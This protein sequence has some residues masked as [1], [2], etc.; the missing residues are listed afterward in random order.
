M[1]RVVALLI[2]EDLEI[3]LVQELLELPLGA[4]APVE[5]PL[6]LERLER[7][8]VVRIVA[9]QRLGEG[10]Q[11]VDVDEADL[12]A[13]AR[14]GRRVEFWAIP[15]RVKPLEVVLVHRGR[16]LVRIVEA[17]EDDSDEEVEEN[18][19]DDHVEYDH[20][21]VDQWLA[22][23]VDRRAALYVVVAAHVGAR[24]VVHEIWAQAGRARLT[25]AGVVERD[26]VHEPVPVLAGREAEKRDE[27]AEERLEVDRLGEAATVELDSREELD[28]HDREDDQQEH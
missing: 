5:A 6:R 8:R 20:V 2:R 18:E 21:R 1:H 19:R 17:L 28:G 11:H 23:A 13:L 12:F 25:A 10:L 9:N 14:A 4:L 15:H 7:V 22:T 24:V 16:R 3:E 26:L 27:R